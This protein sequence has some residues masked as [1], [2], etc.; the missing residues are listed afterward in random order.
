MFDGYNYAP[1][2]AIALYIQIPIYCHNN[3]YMVH[4]YI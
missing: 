2:I 1:T 3:L 4:S